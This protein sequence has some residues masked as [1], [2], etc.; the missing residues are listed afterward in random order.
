MHNS[1]PT[2]LPSSGATQGAG[3]GRLPEAG[4][5]ALGG[6]RDIQ[7]GRE[8]VDV[9][10]TTLRPS[11]RP[12]QLVE[13][14]LGAPVRP[15][16]RLQPQCSGGSA[17]P[18]TFLKRCPSND[19]P[20]NCP[21]CSSHRAAGTQW[22]RRWPPRPGPWQQ[23]AWQPAP[24]LLP[25][26]PLLFQEQ[27]RSTQSAGGS[28]LTL[29]LGQDCLQTHRVPTPSHSS[30]ARSWACLLNRALK[31][32]VLNKLCARFGSSVTAPAS[33]GGCD[34]WVGGGGWQKII[35]SESGRGQRGQQT[36]PPRPGSSVFQKGQPL[37]VR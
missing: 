31:S 16:K 1:R 5:M 22:D 4:G 29:N 17:L 11:Q 30:L 3:L 9:T 24:L 33:G 23:G 21:F 36:S 20:R 19:V 6:T 25:P 12:T 15:G 8:D 35:C 28:E 26:L 18:K 2:C 10:T 27:R 13:P 32:F 37:L 7:T 34:V 14:L